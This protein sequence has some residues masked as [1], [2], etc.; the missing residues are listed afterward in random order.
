MAAT[1]QFVNVPNVKG[2]KF[3][4]A[5]G[6]S[7]KTI[8]TPGSAG[9]R[10]DRISVAHT[11]ETG[12]YLVC[13]IVQSSVVYRLLRI[14]LPPAST[15]NPLIVLEAFSQGAL[16]WVADTTFGLVLPSGTTMQAHVETTLTATKVADVVV[17]GGDF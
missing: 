2:T 5:D 13:S 6:T 16:S 10:I 4:N 12:I 15:A 9:S 17:I 14:Y 11:N 3:E 7:P 8:F 1:P